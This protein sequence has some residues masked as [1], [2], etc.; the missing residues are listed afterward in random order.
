MKNKGINVINYFD[1]NYSITKENNAHTPSNYI[2]NFLRND[3]IY[4]AKNNFLKEIR[5]LSEKGQLLLNFLRFIRHYD[6]LKV[7]INSD[8]VIDQI[9]NSF[10]RFDEIKCLP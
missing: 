4:G 10:I 1:S 2:D 9:Y 5:S 6:K 7:S 3:N 8:N